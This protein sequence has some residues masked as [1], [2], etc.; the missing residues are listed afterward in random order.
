MRNGMAI[1]EFI[2]LGFPGIQGIQIPL[3]TVIFFICITTLAGNGL[4]IA[5]SEPRLQI[6]VY[7]FLCNLSFLEIWYTT[8]VIPK[9]LESFVVAKNSYLHLLPCCLL[10]AFFHYFL[11][12]TEFFILTVMSFDH[13]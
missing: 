6:P 7:F 4:I 3:S 13:D 8:T 9:L 2:I 11:G 10:Q 1:T 5:M 12:T